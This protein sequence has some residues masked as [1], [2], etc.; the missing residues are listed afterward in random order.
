MIH[1][2]FKYVLSS[3]SAGNYE[4]HIHAEDEGN[5]FPLIYH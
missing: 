1:K 2:D 5:L 4:Y 3:K